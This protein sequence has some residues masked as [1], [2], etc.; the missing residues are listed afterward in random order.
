MIVRMF[1]RAIG[2]VRWSLLRTLLALLLFSLYVWFSVISYLFLYQSI[3]PPVQHVAPVHFEFDTHCDASVCSFPTATIQLKKDGVNVLAKNQLYDVKVNL[4]VPESDVNRGIGMFMVNLSFYDDEKA[5]RWSSARTAILRYRS[6]LLSTL[7]LLFYIFPMLFGFLEE[8]QWL[9]I[10]FADNFT[11]TSPGSGFK[12]A[13]VV[14]GTKQLQVYSASLVL[15]ARFSGVRYMMY[16]WPVTSAAVYIA[17]VM[18]FLC[19]ISALILFH[20]FGFR[21]PISLPALPGA[22]DDDDE[23]GEGNQDQANGGGAPAADAGAVAGERAQQRRAG[24]NDDVARQLEGRQ[25]RRAG[26]GGLLIGQ[27]ISDEEP[28]QLGA[29]HP[30]HEPDDDND[31]DVDTDT[32]PNGADGEGDGG[33]NAGNDRDSD[34]GDAAVGAAGADSD[35]DGVDEYG[36]PRVLGLQ[37]AHADI[38]AGHDTNSDDESGDDDDDDD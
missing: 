27:A 26:P 9:L 13:E 20:L 21:L 37:H 28:E 29:L 33:Q 22:D 19:T 8:S 2:F 17:S 15:D 10:V 30:L 18:W 34:R 31:A 23:D 3:V 25:R 38:D 4:E 6:P 1:R 7:R 12:Y 16:Y 36:A 11:D 5:L 24:D 14:V 32:D 35:G